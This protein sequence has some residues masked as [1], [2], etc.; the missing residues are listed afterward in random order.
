V[1]DKEN[2]SQLKQELSK[3]HTI[4][5]KLDFKNDIDHAK[6]PRNNLKQT[7]D[8][9]E[10]FCEEGVEVPFSSMDVML[11]K[12]KEK[13][14][15]FEGTLEEQPFSKNE[16]KSEKVFNVIL[17]YSDECDIINISFKSQTEQQIKISAYNNYMYEIRKEIKAG[18]F[19]NEDDELDPNIIHTCFKLEPPN[20]VT[21]SMGDVFIDYMIFKDTSL[22]TVSFYLDYKLQ[23][24]SV[25]NSKWRSLED[26]GVNKSNY[27]ELDA[28]LENSV[29]T[30]VDNTIDIYKAGY[31]KNE[32]YIYLK[33]IELS[34]GN[35]KLLLYYSGEVEVEYF[36]D[37]KVFQV[38]PEKFRFAEKEIL[39]LRIKMNSGNKL[40]GLFIVNQENQR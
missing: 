14:G 15:Y 6:S 25:N 20:I 1:F 31:A 34:K 2:I 23:K 30:L 32:G 38:L 5:Y 33:P 17:P 39:N 8:Y 37:N 40:Y 24:I 13:E 35:Y 3:N 10:F 26:I 16:N 21:I 28:S 9:C 12:L 29:A 19:E 7:D 36:K 11:G 4:F 27:F 18:V 22:E